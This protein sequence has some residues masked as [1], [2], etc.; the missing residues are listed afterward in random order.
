MVRGKL[1]LET[2]EGLGLQFRARSGS[3]HTM[4]LDNEQGDKGPRPME[5]VLLALGG[6]T[7]MDVI[8][9]L[10]KK[11]QTVTSYEIE[12]AGEKRTEHPSYFTR[13]EILH[14]LRGRIDPEAARHAI[15][16]SETKYCSVGAMIG[17]TAQIVHKFEILPPEDAVERQKPVRAISA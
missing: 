6:C 7:A 10:R 13:V 12:L 5:T 17:K 11:R 9:I 4:V 15:E 3:G 16:L 8:S 2:V 14:R 1:E